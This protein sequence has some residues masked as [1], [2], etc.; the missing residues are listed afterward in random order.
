MSKM[1]DDSKRLLLRTGCLCCPMIVEVRRPRG[2]AVPDLAAA[3]APA[4]VRC[5]AVHVLLAG[6]AQVAASLIAGA[7]GQ[8]G[9]ALGQQHSQG[10]Q[11]RCSR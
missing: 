10:R 5:L 1:N 4:V 2:Q 7:E 9:R 8:A 11:A 3:P 6:F